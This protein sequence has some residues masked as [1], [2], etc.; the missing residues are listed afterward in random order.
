LGLRARHARHRRV[1]EAALRIT[2]TLIAGL[3]LVGGA[4]GGKSPSISSIS[5]TSGVVGASVTINGANFGSSQ[6]SS[7]LTF[8]GI[9]ATP[10]SWK[11]GV[12]VAAVPAN[13]TSGPVVVNVGGVASNSVTFTVTPVTNGLSPTSGAAGTSVTISGSGF[14]AS[15]GSSTVSFNGT[16][17]F[18]TNWSAA[19]ITVPVPSAATTGPVVVTVSGVS[20]SGIKFTV[21]PTLVSIAV[22]PQN[23]SVPVGLGEQFAAT[24]TY[25]DKSTKDLT[26]LA[27]WTSL[28]TTAA[29][30][31]G[32]GLAMGRSV[33]NTTITAVYGNA[34]ASS[35]LSVTAP[36]LLTIT[37]APSN[38]YI[39][40]SNSQQFTAT[41]TYSDGSRQGITAAVTWSSSNSSVATIGAGG[42]ATAGTAGSSTILAM[43]NGVASS[44]SV[45]VT[46]GGPPTITAT[47]APPPN[48]AGWNNSNVTVTFTCIPGSAAI[49]TCPSPQALSSEGASQVVSGTVTDAVGNTATATVT[50]NIDKTPPALAVTAPTDGEVITNSPLTATGNVSDAL[51]GV[52]T[53]TCNQ[54]PVT[55]T[56]GSFSCNIS[57]NPG[58]NLVVVRVTDVAG[59][60]ALTKMHVVLNGSWPLPSSLQITPANVNVVVGGTQQFTAVDNQGRP[61]PDATWTVSNTTVATITTAASPVLTALAAGTV[62]LTATVQGVSTQLS[63][64]ILSSPGSSGSVQWSASVLQDQDSGGI[65]PA[66]PIAGSPGVYLLD[67]LTN[68]TKSIRAFSEDGEQLWQQTLS[69]S[70]APVIPD[71]LGGLFTVNGT[72]LTTLDAQTGSPV[73]QY[74]FRSPMGL[75]YASLPDGSSLPGIAFRQDAGVIVLEA[76]VSDPVPVNGGYV[77]VFDGNTGNQTLRLPLPQ[78]LASETTNCYPNQSYAEATAPLTSP[79]VVDSAGNTYLE[80]LITNEVGSDICEWNGSVETETLADARSTTVFLLTVFPDGSTSTQTLKADSY[81]SQGT[82]GG[83]S[84]SAGST[85]LPGIVIPDGQGGVL[86]TWAGI[87]AVGGAQA[88]VMDISSAG[89]STY[90]LPFNDGGPNQLILGSNGVAFGVDKSNVVAFNVD[91]GQVLWSYTPPNR[92]Y[93]N[94]ATSDG[95]VTIT[96]LSA[97]PYNPSQITALDPNG[98]ATVLASV[99]LDG[100]PVYSWSGVWYAPVTVGTG[101][102]QN[103]SIVL[104]PLT[105]ADSFWGIP[106]GNESGNGMSIEQVQTNQAQ[107]TDEQLPAFGATLNTNY[108]SIE[109]LTGVSPAQIF[110]QY[111]QTFAGAQPGN[112]SV[113]TVPAN[114][115]VTASGQVLTFTLRGL[116]SLGQGP[117]SVEVER[118]DT[119]A[120]TISAVT[121]KGHPLEGWRYWRVFSIG[122]NDVVIE[123]GSAD[124]PGP[125]KKNY[126][127]YYFFSFN[128]IEIWHQYLEYIKKKLGASQGSNFQYNLVQGEWGYRSQDYILNNVCQASWCN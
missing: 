72:G 32:L 82:V 42:L 122:T 124:L 104:P 114:T 74:S 125:G 116:T 53:V 19:A 80:Y 47:V 10:T 112:N 59:N 16:A 110:S 62:T 123:T 23:S 81:T 96:A 29:T 18:P 25:S 121:L 119:S 118:F 103:S 31:N 56:G 27:S 43:S 111:I 63:V 51:S 49:T 83:N 41:G 99:A 30:I 84:W 34:S 21:P 28:N 113:A 127:G 67:N 66:I 93:I 45:T 7:T 24:G 115:N 120:D 90:Q 70:L 86:A 95:G 52:G 2:A 87:P 37:I 97:S 68:E 13:A 3:L 92:P 1:L 14:G 100:L 54:A 44:T 60:A 65:F 55:V 126:W 36:S 15:Q 5:P 91:S 6:G 107:G 76:D 85:D 61:R 17:A 39:P 22:S 75:G 35:A 105:L 69:S 57:L 33:G 8:N 26:T 108:N 94:A 79:I 101:E 73:W 88:M 4:I 50:V 20:T 11:T 128:Q 89:S 40:P 58:T 71:V 117:F 46:A 12:I 78:G 38:S 98:I 102:F 9:K 77:D 48:T 106:G 64:T 109:L